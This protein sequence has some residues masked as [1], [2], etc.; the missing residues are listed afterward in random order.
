M[1]GLMWKTIMTMSASATLKE[2]AVLDLDAEIKQNSDMVFIESSSDGGQHFIE[3]YNMELL[4]SVSPT[5]TLT[6]AL[7]EPPPDNGNFISFAEKQ[8]IYGQSLFDYEL[9][10]DSRV[11][12]NKDQIKDIHYASW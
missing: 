11:I 4:E 1:Y 5:N 6:F 9:E 10:I 3:P 7:Q 12:E 8:N 2:M